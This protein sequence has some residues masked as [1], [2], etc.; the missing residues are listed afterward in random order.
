[1]KD[2]KKV[3]MSITISKELYDY[4]EQNTSNKS[5]YIDYILYMYYHNMGVDVSKIKL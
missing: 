4:I 3:K 2:E 5:K 1:M